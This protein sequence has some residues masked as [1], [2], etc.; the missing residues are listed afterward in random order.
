MKRTAII[1]RTPLARSTKPIK[2]RSNSPVRAE[3]QRL[4]EQA[5]SEAAIALQA[6]QGKPFMV[7]EWP[8]CNHLASDCHHVAGRRGPNLFDKSKLRFVCR[9]CHIKIHHDPKAA[10]KLGLIQ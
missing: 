6:K 2:K 3:R 7:C 1:R 4:Y 9:S 8:D 5:R 10:R